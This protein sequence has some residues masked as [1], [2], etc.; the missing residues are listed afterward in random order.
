MLQLNPAQKKW[1]QTATLEERIAFMIKG[2][3]EVYPMMDMK[4]GETYFAP[5]LRGTRIG[6]TAYK[7]GAEALTVGREWQQKQ[8]QRTD[9]PVL[10]EEALGI[11]TA[12]QDLFEE[13]LEHPFRI[14]RII[15]LATAGEEPCEALT[16]F[17]EDDLE[18]DLEIFPLTDEH[19]EHLRG[20]LE[21][22]E[23]SEALCLLHDNGLYGWLAQVEQPVVIEGNASSCTYSWGYCYS[24]WLYAESYEKVLQKAAEWS[25]QRRNEDFEKLGQTERNE[26]D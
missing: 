2:T 5:F 6:S 1:A 24:Q 13:F 7:T 10:D 9:L 26:E 17:I 15:H 14:A 21:D 20:Y 4:S 3:V 25:E 22:R 16:S 23:P 11:S 18:D 12:N 19:K 8:K